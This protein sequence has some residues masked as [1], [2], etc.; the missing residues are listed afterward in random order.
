MREIIKKTVFV[1]AVMLALG[2]SAW[3]GWFTFEPN[4]VVLDGTA[5][6]RELDDI[7]KESLY[8]QKGD[9]AGA[10]QLIDDLRVSIIKN[11]NKGTPV[12]YIGYEEYEG[13]VFVRVED[14]SGSKLWADM[15]GIACE[16]QDGKERSVTKMDLEKGEFAP[17]SKA[18]R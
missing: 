8:L 10:Q 13:K 11:E 17:L 16:G 5:V 3:G 18:T 14:E 1:F 7:E 2:G 4:V 12:K 15:T 6:A 9:T